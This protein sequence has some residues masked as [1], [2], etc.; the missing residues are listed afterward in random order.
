[1]CK[2]ILKGIRQLEAVNI[3]KPVLDMGID[4]KLCQVQNFSTQVES[5]PETQLLSLLRGQCPVKLN[6]NKSNVE[7]YE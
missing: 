7:E 2:D 6:I 4:N 1:M 3:A 5:I